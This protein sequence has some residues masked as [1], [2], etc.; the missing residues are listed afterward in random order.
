MVSTW[1]LGEIK[2]RN[3]IWEHGINFKCFIL[4]AVNSNLNDQI[5]ELKWEA[6]S[7][8]AAPPGEST[9]QLTSTETPNPSTPVTESS[10]TAAP[11]TTSTTVETTSQL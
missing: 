11:A 2:G 1:T 4:A 5:D 7:T 6:T 9:T 3:K 8:T 10:T